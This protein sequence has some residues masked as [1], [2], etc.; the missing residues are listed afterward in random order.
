[1]AVGHVGKGDAISECEAWDVLRDFLLLVV[2][3]HFLGTAEDLAL[4]ICPAVLEAAGHLL[5]HAHAQTRE[6]QVI[7]IRI[8]L[9]HLFSVLHCIITMDNVNLQVFARPCSLQ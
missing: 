9:V 5:T 8:S 6:Y 1:M 4:M 7:S 3:Q 2:Q